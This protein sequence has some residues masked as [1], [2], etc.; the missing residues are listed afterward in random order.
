MNDFGVAGTGAGTNTF[1]SLTG[2]TLSNGTLSNNGGNYN[3]QNGTVSAVLA[4]TN[5][6]NKTT[7]GTITLSG[8]N[9]YT[10]T[11]TVTAGR[12]RRARR[13]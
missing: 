7:A 13:T 5:G 1:G 3:L 11:T 8:A 12:M 10:G 4:G 6:V 2:G 9:T